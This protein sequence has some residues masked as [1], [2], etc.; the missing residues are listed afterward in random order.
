M[1]EFHA[2]TSDIRA[3]CDDILSKMEGSSW[4]IPKLLE[5]EWA[6]EYRKRIGAVYTELVPPRTVD[7]TR[8]MTLM[9]CHAMIMAA[10]AANL[11][12]LPFNDEVL[13][14]LGADAMRTIMRR[15]LEMYEAQ[16]NAP[17]QNS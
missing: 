16:E 3:R 14:E 17:D 1:N 10:A 12:R 9:C 5:C 13:A 7:Q 4:L 6:H 2:S 8:N 11:F 15:A